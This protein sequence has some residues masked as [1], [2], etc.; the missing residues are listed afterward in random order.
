MGSQ[1]WMTRFHRA[2]TWEVVILTEKESLF[3][4]DF[5]NSLESKLPIHFKIEVAQDPDSFLEKA[6]QA[7]LLWARKDWILKTEFQLT[8]FK[9]QKKMSELLSRSLSADFFDP[10]ET[11]ATLLPFLWTLP[12]VRI[13]GEKNPRQLK[14]LFQ[15]PGKV[16]WPFWGLE[17]FFPDLPKD[18]SSNTNGKEQWVLFP[19]STQNP[20]MEKYGTLWFPEKKIR[21]FVIYLAFVENAKLPLS[22][23]QEIISEWLDPR[24]MAHMTFDTKMALTLVQAEE[25]LPPWQ[26]AS[27]LRK[28]DLSH[29]QR[30]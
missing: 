10:E 21:P 27:A 30:P 1:G 6:S 13:K 18:F 26:R 11:S 7:D 29:L 17:D 3:P 19:Y 5:K 14:E 2:Q 24:L 20:E 23:K 28:V 12:L 4:E 22:V 15:L 8:D 25:L 16:Q 9:S